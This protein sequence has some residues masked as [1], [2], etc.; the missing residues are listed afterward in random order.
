L[1][2]APTRVRIA[3]STPQPRLLI[4]CDSYYPGWKVTV[5]GKESHIELI[6]Q[7]FRGVFVPSGAHE[8]IFQYDPLSFRIGKMISLFTIFSLIFVGC[9]ARFARGTS[10]RPMFENG[11]I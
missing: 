7:V 5:D 2:Y 1:E 8:I 9:W 3:A 4:L 6:D 10:N 11:K